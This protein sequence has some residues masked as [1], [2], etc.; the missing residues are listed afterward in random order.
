MT[1]RPSLLLLPVAV[2]ADLAATA[3]VLVGVLVGPVFGSPL[4]RLACRVVGR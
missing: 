4:V 1:N 2:A 3:L